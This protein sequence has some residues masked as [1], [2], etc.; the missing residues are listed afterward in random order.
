M[1]VETFSHAALSLWQSAVHTVLHQQGARVAPTLSSDHPMM[2]Q[3]VVA[4]KVLNGESSGGEQI[5]HE[6]LVA[7]KLALAT[8][9][10]DERAI[11]E[12]SKELRFSDCDPTWLECICVYETFLATKQPIPYAQH[13]HLNDFVLSLP[14]GQEVVIAVLGDWGTG[15]DDAKILLNQ[16]A[17]HRPDVLLHLG[18]IYYSCTDHEAQTHFYDVVKEQFPSPAGIAIPTYT[19][20][21]NHDMY[22]GG[23]AYY[24]LLDQLGQPA[25]YFCLRNDHW[26]ILAMDTGYHDHDVFTVATNI[27]F[28]EPSEVAWHQDKI[29]NA[30]GR[31]TILLSH[32]QLFSCS[33]GGIGKDGDGSAHALNPHLYAAFESPAQGVSLSDIDLWL[34]GHEHNLLIF[35]SWAGLQ[36][37]RCIGASAI[38]VRIADHP[39]TCDTNLALPPHTSALPTLHDGTE[40]EHDSEYYYRCYAIIRL[41]GSQ[42]VVEYYQFDIDTHTSTCIYQEQIA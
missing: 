17:T 1:G 28:L 32:H 18:D 4:G 11:E 22:S 26:Q 19:L 10:K 40:L 41:A 8:F 35:Q 9:H 36:R 24:K 15:T 5:A 16:A 6:A 20:A 27:T 30:A 2:Q 3:A 42:A 21:G 38:P 37:G 12:L 34:W 29:R 14:A 33:K 31:K 13:E 25:S 23:G 39:Y 7:T